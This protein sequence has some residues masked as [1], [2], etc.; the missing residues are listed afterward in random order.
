MS[1]LTLADEILLEIVHLTLKG[2]EHGREDIYELAASCKR[3]K[4]ICDTV[5]W[6]KYT[7]VIRLPSVSYLHAPRAGSNL[8][9]KQWWALFH[10]RIAHLL[11][12]ASVVRD[13]TLVDSVTSHWGYDSPQG[14]PRCPLFAREVMDAVIPAVAA[15][16][17]ITSLRV[18]SGALDDSACWPD[19]LWPLIQR[20]LAHLHSLELAA[21]FHDIPR[22]DGPPK[23]LKSLR[24]RWCAGLIDGFVNQ[25][26]IFPQY[27]KLTLLQSDAAP[28]P[29]AN[30]FTPS[31]KIARQ[32][33]AFGIE[34]THS[35]LQTLEPAPT[36]DLSNIPRAQ[37]VIQVPF[38]HEPRSG[39]RAAWRD[40]EARIRRVIVGGR[41]PLH[42]AKTDD[43]AYAWR[44][45]LVD[46]SDHGSR[47]RDS[48]EVIVIDVDAY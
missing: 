36:C 20:E 41:G 14:E 21:N 9:S 28:G 11:S 47:R 16:R 15:C 25:N 31:R 13:L 40:T 46:E 38:D 17:S 26:M 6:S 45:A 27:L 37:I 10:T 39:I 44:P 8:S 30:R 5:L 43:C 48:N 33:Q 24:L 32:L 42:I 35:D 2:D 1:L 12:K 22:L 3:F 4:R 23:K 34:I 18:R 29:E 7:L 19:K